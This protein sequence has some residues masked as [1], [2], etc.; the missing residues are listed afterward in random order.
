[1]LIA[2][3]GVPVTG[4]TPAIRPGGYDRLAEAF[5]PGVN[6]PLVVAVSLPGRAADKSL[7]RLTERLSDDRGVVDVSAPALNRAGDHASSWTAG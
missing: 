2:V 4:T 3:A 5:G 1:M 6:G 7:E